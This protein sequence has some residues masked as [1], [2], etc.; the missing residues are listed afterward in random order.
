MALQTIIFCTT[1]IVEGTHGPTYK[2][3]IK[4]Y[5]YGHL[6]IIKMTKPSSKRLKLKFKTKYLL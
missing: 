2:I 5:H 1:R 4:I 6:K 3:S